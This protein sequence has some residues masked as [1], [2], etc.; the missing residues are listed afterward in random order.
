MKFS[1]IFLLKTLKI[2]NKIKLKIPHNPALVLVAACLKES[3]SVDNKDMCRSCCFGII[4]INQIME[5]AQLS[6]IEYQRVK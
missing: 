1:A 6:I 4:H 3:N 5:L 2:N